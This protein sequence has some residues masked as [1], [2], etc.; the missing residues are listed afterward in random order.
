MLRAAQ[1]PAPSPVP[2]YLSQPVSQSLDHDAAVVVTLLLVGLAQLLHPE[3]GD[4]KQAQVVAD[5]G[6]QRSDEV[7]EAVVWVRAGRVLLGLQTQPVDRWTLAQIWGQHAK[8]SNLISS[9]RSKLHRGTSVLFP[10]TSP[11]LRRGPDT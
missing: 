3:A 4:G 2:L 9:D 5:A 1:H 8:D 11:V 7:R 10:V 6:M